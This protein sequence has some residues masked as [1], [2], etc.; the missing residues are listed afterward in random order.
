MGGNHFHVWRFFYPPTGGAGLANG[1]DLNVEGK[2]LI[3]KILLG[4]WPSDTQV[5]RKAS[6]NKNAEGA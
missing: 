6:C 5:N 3:R 2:Q 4:I 1:F